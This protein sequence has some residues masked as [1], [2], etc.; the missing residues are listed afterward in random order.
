MTKR[1]RKLVVSLGKVLLGL[2]ILLVVY[3]L[4]VV[5]KSTI[6]V[7][8]FFGATF[9]GAELLSIIFEGNDDED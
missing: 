1:S 5:D 2:A 4:R 7:S 6:L 8:L 3:N 9:W